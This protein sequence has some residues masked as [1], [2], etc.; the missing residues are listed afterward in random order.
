M[1]TLKPKS[2]GSAIMVS[3]FIDEQIGYLANT[4]QEAREYLENGVNKE[5]F[6]NNDRFMK[7][8]QKTVTIFESVHPEYQG[9]FIFDNSPNHTKMPEDALNVNVMNVNPGGNQPKLRNTTWEGKEQEMTFPDGRPKGMRLV[10]LERGINTTGMKAADMRD[11]WSM[12]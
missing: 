1:Q 11:A 4:H 7:Q 2:M 6:W 5:G 10:L 9:V 8:V 3:D 12:S